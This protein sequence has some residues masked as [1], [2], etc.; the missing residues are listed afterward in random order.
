MNGERRKKMRKFSVLG[1]KIQVRGR[2]GDAR[3][4]RPPP[5]DPLVPFIYQLA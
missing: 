5:L 2:K 1:I 3:R 4:V